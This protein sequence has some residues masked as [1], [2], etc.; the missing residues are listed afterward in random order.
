MKIPLLPDCE[1]GTARKATFSHAGVTTGFLEGQALAAGALVYGMAF[2]ML[3]GQAQFSAIEATLMSAFVYS[4]SAQL[5]VLQNKA[6]GNFLLPAITI[7]LMM[8]ARY[9][10]YG[11]ALRPWLGSLPPQMSYLSLFFLGDGNWALS[12]K[13]YASGEYDAGFVLGSGLAMYVAWVL[14]TVV[15]YVA[16]N[17]VGDPKSFA[18]DFMLI[19]FSTALAVEFWKGRALV[20]PALAALLMALC[21]DRV[22]S[23]GWTIVASGLMGGVVAFF[24]PSG[25]RP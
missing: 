17:T 21:C 6:I 5:A 7:V 25:E 16:G 12:M 22:V 14:G 23:G 20:A 24:M 13:R 1:K 10:L 11:A 4:G 15:G 2:G 3:A 8:N 18:V 9:L 19:A